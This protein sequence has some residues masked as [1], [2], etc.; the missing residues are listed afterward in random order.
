SCCRDWGWTTG[1]GARSRRRRWRCCATRWGRTIGLVNAGGAIATSYGYE[2]FG[3]T[4]ASGAA[5]SDSHQFTGREQDPTGLYYLRNRYYNP[6]LGR[7]LSPDPI[8]IAGGINLYAYAGNDPLN[9]VDRVG[10]GAGPSALNGYGGTWSWQWG[11]HGHGGGWG[12]GGGSGD[13]GNGPG[14]P[15]GPGGSG[16]GLGADSAGGNFPG[17]DI[18][19][20]NQGGQSGF[21]MAA[22][23]AGPETPGEAG[24]APACGCGP[25]APPGGVAG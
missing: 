24:I 17:S 9:L 7:F 18:G 21:A 23:E 8:G 6:M 1:S 20:N 5:S 10:L 11:S 22:A 19:P 25:T 2:P 12:P 14:G 4:A 13:D 16:Y 3:A 15:G